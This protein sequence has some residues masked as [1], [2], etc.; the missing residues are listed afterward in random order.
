[1]SWSLR[2]SRGVWV[3]DRPWVMGIVNVT[4]D[5]FSDGGSFLD[6][7]AAVEHALQLVHEGA[8]ILDL[9]AESTRPGSS[10]VPVEEE[11]RRL[12]P[13]IKALRR[14][15]DIPLSVDTSQPEV[16]RQAAA[17]GVNLL[18]DVRALMLPGALEVAAETGLAVCLMHMQGQPLHMQSN[19]GYGNL[20]QEVMSFLQGRVKAC[21][22]TGIDQRSICVDPGFGFGKTL[23]HNLELM[24][25]L[26][27]LLEL[28]P[29]LVGA[30]RKSM[31]GAAL[32]GRPVHER[33]P[34]GLAAALWAAKEGAAILR[35]HDVQATCDVL[36]IWRLIEEHKA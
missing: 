5:S 12:I 26:H 7:E 33:M 27:D 21:L 2:H 29:V 19:P 4:P 34:A 24:A 1:M 3:S 20:R 28:G 14:R 36:R 13:V 17:E 32:G 25:H 18:N 10:P 15:T 11:L 9:G 23:Q 22:E 30:S 31:L 16:M 35:T 6:P 8:D